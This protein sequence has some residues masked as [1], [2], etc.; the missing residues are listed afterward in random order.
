MKISVIITV[1]NEEK[2]IRRCLESLKVQTF[3]KFEIIVIDDGSTDDT[4]KVLS[5][6][7]IGQFDNSQLT[8]LEQNHQGLASARNL[9]AEKAKGEILVFLD[10]DMYFEKDFLERLCAPIIGG[11]AKGTFSTEEFVA[12]WDNVWARCWNYNWNMPD[13][14]RIDP[15]RKDQQRE[16]R[17]ILKKE[18]EKGGGLDS[19]GYTDAWSL[20]EKLGYNPVATKAKYYH[21]NPASLSEV[22]MQAK[23]SAKRKYKLG[24]IGDFV[25]LIRA[26]PLFSLII[27]GYKAIIKGEPLFIVFK[28][29]FGFAV[30]MGILSKRKKYA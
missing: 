18:F 28:I 9:G 24:I 30:I 17:A 27:G 12:N 11:E 21:Y 22:F 13:K 15:S 14:R 29:V 10:G 3:N 16:F 20:V 6:L 8:I 23:W 25:A 26:N 7:S 19:R 1:Y 2:Y 4:L 5:Q